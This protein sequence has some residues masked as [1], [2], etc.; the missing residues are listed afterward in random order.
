V[1]DL[2]KVS[3]WLDS[4]QK[5][6][7]GNVK[8]LTIPYHKGFVKLTRVGRGGTELSLSVVGTGEE[9]QSALFDF[10]RFCVA[11]RKAAKEYLPV[12]GSCRM[13]LKK[14]RK[15]ILESEAAAF[16][17]QEEWIEDVLGHNHLFEVIG[18]LKYH[19]GSGAIPRSGLPEYFR[20]KHQDKVRRT[21]QAASENA[22]IMEFVM[23][24][25]PP[26]WEETKKASVRLTNLA[27]QQRDNER[28]E[29]VDRFEASQREKKLQK[30]QARKIGEELDKK[31]KRPVDKNAPVEEKEK[32]KKIKT[33]KT[34]DEDGFT[35]FKPVVEVEE[36]GVEKTEKP[37]KTEKK[38]KKEE[39]K[40][41]PKIDQKEKKPKKVE[42]SSVGFEDTNPYAPAL[43]E[44]SYA[45]VAEVQHKKNMSKSQNPQPQKAPSTPPTQPKPEV[46]KP[47]PEGT[48]KPAEV[49]KKPTEVAKK[50]TEVTKKPT[51]VTKKPAES[52]EPKKTSETNKKP[53]KPTE[54]PKKTVEKQIPAKKTEKQPSTSK[55]PEKQN[56]KT[57]KSAEKEKP[58][59]NKQAPKTPEDSSEDEPDT[60][61]ENSHTEDPLVNVVNISSPDKKKMKQLA[62]KNKGAKQLPFYDH[63]WFQPVVAVLGVVV[64]VALGYSLV[65][66]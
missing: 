39:K 1:R 28:Q 57:P 45:S 23:D 15:N 12:A 17:E 34:V 7:I 53:A 2:S 64:L 29:R 32:K 61:P 4:I 43:K 11:L 41:D 13:G 26:F 54:P 40:I 37:G 44:G 31:T 50:P 5:L 33:V 49:T 58:K 62:R 27:K 65:L 42:A 20:Q 16:K 52:P 66:S 24:N 22:N 9:P 14:L 60:T 46:K 48:K 18:H 8:S 56:P 10:G 36:K 55:Q 63:E 19:L 3:S 21:S 51:E 59:Q 30:E 38:E 25:L 6:L 35:S 47:V